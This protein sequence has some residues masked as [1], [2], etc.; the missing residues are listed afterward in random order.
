MG[1]IWYI[2]GNIWASLETL[3]ETSG[4][5]FETSLE[6]SGTSLNTSRET[7]GDILG[8]IQD[9]LGDIQDI[10]RGIQDYLRDNQ[11]ILRDI[12][13]ILGDIPYGVVFFKCFCNPFG[14][15]QHTIYKKTCFIEMMFI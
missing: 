12:Q 7:S 4:T 13:D 2:Q 6:I 3:R 8:D 15:L 10:L 11:D 14:H 1:D 9:I 5:S